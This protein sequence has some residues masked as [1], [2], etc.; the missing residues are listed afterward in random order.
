M[1]RRALGELGELIAIKTL[2][3]R[4][5]EKII[6]INDV[7]INYPFADL[8]AEKE[9]N[10]YVISVKSR[11]KYEKNSIKIN[12]RY[13]LGKNAHENA[14]KA[15]IEYN[16]KAYWMAIQFDVKSYSVFFGSLKELEELEN[17]NAIPVSKC[18]KEECGKILA[19]DVPHYFDFSY[20]GNSNVQE[21]NE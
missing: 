19:K 4:G 10:K 1:R 18:M 2:V 20:F 7:K 13:K 12:N 6:N 16:A 8:Y 5:Y 15:E 9:G 3:Y 21:I 11:N 14:E 17:A